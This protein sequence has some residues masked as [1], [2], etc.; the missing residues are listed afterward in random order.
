MKT[1]ELERRLPKNVQLR[2]VRLGKGGIM[3]CALAQEV[4]EDTPTGTFIV[5]DPDGHAWSRFFG[6]N[7]HPEEIKNRPDKTR[8]QLFVD[9]FSYTRDERFDVK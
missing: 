6:E 3:K 4:K 9:G 1:G 8:N 2:H 7:K 5:Y